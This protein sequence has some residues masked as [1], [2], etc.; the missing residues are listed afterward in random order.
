MTTVDTRN[1]LHAIAEHVLAPALYAATRHIGLQPTPGGFG[2]PSFRGAHG[3]RQLFVRE[4]SLI[5]RD[6]GEERRTGLTTLGELS[7]FVGVSPGVPDEVYLA[8]TP[9]DVDRPLAVDP[10]AER[11]LAEWFALGNEALLQLISLQAATDA[12]DIQLWPEHFDLATTINQVNFGASP[13]DAEHDEPYLYVG[14][15][16]Q[17]SGPFW[18]ESFGASVSRVE[19]PDVA[20]AVDFFSTGFDLSR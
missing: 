16:E 14:P 20:A 3:E 17:R 2:T 6:G 9:L 5:D 11:A 19:V 7:T 10:A 15:F 13:G 8:S 4:T 18:N 1:A 12:S